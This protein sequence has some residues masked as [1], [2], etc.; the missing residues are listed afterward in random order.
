M[1]RLLEPVLLEPVRDDIEPPELVLLPRTDS[2]LPDVCEDE[3]AE[4]RLPAS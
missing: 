1:P 4:P 3:R 2:G